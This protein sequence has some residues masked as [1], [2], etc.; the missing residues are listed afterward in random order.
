MRKK[1]GLVAALWLA[2]M[3]AP[4]AAEAVVV[5]RVVAVVGERAILLTDV[6]RRARPYLARLYAALPP[7]PQRAG[8]ESKVMKD[9]LERMV[10][11][12]LETIAAARQNVRVTAEE[13]DQALRRVAK[14]AGM[15]LAEL[16]RDV[17][18]NTGLTQTEYR[19]EIRRQVLEGKLLQR[20]IQNQRVTKAELERMFDKV[21]KQ[22]RMILLYQPAWIVL[23]LGKDASESLVRSRMAQA[24]EI[25]AQARAGTDFA[26]LAEEYSEDPSTVSEGGDLGIRVPTHSPRAQEGEYKLLAKEL[27]E[28]A[29]ALEV[30]EVTEPFVYKDEA[31]VILT[32]TRRQPSR[33]VSIDAVRNEMA[34]RVQSEKLQ[35]IKDKWLEDLR[36][37]THVDVR[38]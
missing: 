24:R 33:Y 6:R 19:Q 4:V 32:V 17:E 38:M 10:D 25:V 27:E 18:T 16:Y 3:L 36:R 5:E 7:G 23:R 11:E 35:K 8:A 20:Q 12:E 31:I 29:L 37:R 28:R 22:E 2:V 1:L 13:V 21:R 15:P 30:G 9:M 14:A 26:T 34:E